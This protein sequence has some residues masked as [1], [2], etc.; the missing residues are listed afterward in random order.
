MECMF[1]DMYDHNFSIESKAYGSI[2]FG[3][4]K[5]ILHELHKISGEQYDEYYCPSDY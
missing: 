1:T 4:F 5:R 2:T 3:E